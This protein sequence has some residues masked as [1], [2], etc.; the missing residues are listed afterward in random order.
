MQ[1]PTG[2]GGDGCHAQRAPPL[3]LAAQP[4]PTHWLV[5]QPAPAAAQP[6]PARYPSHAASFAPMLAQ[7]AALLQRPA[8]QQL[9]APRPVTRILHRKLTRP[10]AGGAAHAGGRGPLAS[11]WP[12]TLGP[13]AP[14]PCASRQPF[15]Y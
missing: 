2:S 1:Q 11:A 5:A 14:L 15:L 6:A 10:A 12:E 3:W 9:A 7:Q 8:P 13:R 4:A